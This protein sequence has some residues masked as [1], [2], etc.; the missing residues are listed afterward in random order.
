MQRGAA[1]D[2]GRQIVGVWL[3]RDEEY[4]AAW[5]LMNAVEFCDR[6]LVMD[7]RSRDRTR[8]ILEAVA[9]RYRH[10]EILD[11]DD[12]YDTHKY[13]EAYAGTPTWVFGIDGDEIYDPAG[14]KQ[15]RSRLLAGEFDGYWRIAGH[16]LH[17]LGIRFER[18]EAFGY[19]QPGAPEVTKLYNF[20]A[21]ESWSPGP[22]ERL[23]GLKSIVFRPNLGRDSILKVWQ[24]QSWDQANFRCLH[25]AFMPRSPLDPPTPGETGGVTGRANPS[26]HMKASSILRRVRRAVLRRL[27]PD[28]DTKRNYK[29]RHYTKGPIA[30]FDIT[31]FGSPDAW[32]AIDRGYADALEAIR[33]TTERHEGMRLSS[34]EH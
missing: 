12:A 31:G 15:M 2:A 5:S 26:E 21:V 32:R 33:T 3:L 8:E 4:F 7:N 23:H 29:R 20:G 27:D 34:A 9:A 17:V 30:T 6:V 16:M 14:L 11:V 1:M 19:A 25:L 10:V 13:L 28:H 22:H 24:H 18:T